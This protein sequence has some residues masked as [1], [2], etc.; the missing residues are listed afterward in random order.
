MEDVVGLGSSGRTP[1]VA[2][3]DPTVVYRPAALKGLSVQFSVLNLFNSIKPLQVYE[4]KY[5]V[6]STGT[7]TDFFNHEKGKYYTNPRYARLQVQ[8]DW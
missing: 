2:S 6:D 5:S 3:L 1:W 7:V 4:T 8:Y